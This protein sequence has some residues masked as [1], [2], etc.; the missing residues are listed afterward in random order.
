MLFEVDDNVLMKNGEPVLTDM[1]MKIMPV[2]KSLRIKVVYIGDGN[3][4]PIDLSLW[5]SSVGIT[6]INVNGL[7]ST[8][9]TKFKLT[10]G[11]SIN[12]TK[13]LKFSVKGCS[14]RNGQLHQ[15]NAIISSPIDFLTLIKSAMKTDE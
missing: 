1:A 10:I 11:V 12:I 3:Y 4:T 6:S 15:I 14:E 7:E 9:G 5:L 2:E 8:T 13:G